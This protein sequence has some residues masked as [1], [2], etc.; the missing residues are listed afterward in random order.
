MKKL[1]LAATAA[2]S[3]LSAMATPKVINFWHFN[4]LATAYHN[5]GIPAINA[6]Y[7]AIDTNKAQIVYKLLPGT[8]AAYAG[9]IDNVAGTDTNTRLGIT[10]AGTAN[11]ALRVRNPS[12]SEYL[13]LYIPTKGYRNIALS[14]VLESSSTTSGMLT[15]NFDYSTDSGASWKTS[16]LSISTLDVSQA[17]FQGTNWGL[18]SLNFSADTAGTNNNNRLVFRIKFA[19][20]TSLTTGNNRFDN[21]V[22]EGDS[23][24]VTGGSHVAVSN[25]TAGSEF[26]VYPNPA[27]NAL[28]VH[29]I[30]AGAKTIDVY[31][32][33]GEKVLSTIDAAT[34]AQLNISGLAHGQYFIRVTTQGGASATARFIKE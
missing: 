5:P 32:V 6:N 4:N 7:S 8:S 14:Y 17:K 16:G 10:A 20:N 23:I 18:V 15:Q 30:S 22:V 19:G 27:G 24:A 3:T 9:Y 1:I 31:T 21:I 2:L 13:Q 33:T 28:F 29:S 34:D 12:D 26:T 11:N 25:V